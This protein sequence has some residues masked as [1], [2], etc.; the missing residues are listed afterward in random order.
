MSYEPAFSRDEGI[1]IL[2][3]NFNSLYYIELILTV[4]NSVINL[5]E[6]HIKVLKTNH[7]NLMLM[8]SYFGW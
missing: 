3:T 4:I 1:R 5:Y 7:P 2:L 8:V 6:R